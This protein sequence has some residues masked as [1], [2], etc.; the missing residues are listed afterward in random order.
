M[1]KQTRNIKRGVLLVL[2]IAT[3]V[4]VVVACKGG[5]DGTLRVGQKAIDFELRDL[6]GTMHRLSDYRGRR[7]HLHF[8]AD[9]CPLCH[10]EFEDMGNVYKELKKKYPDFEILGVNVDQPTVH[11]EEFIK[12]HQVEFPILLDVGS[13]VARAYGLKG[14]PCNFLVGRDGKIK[15]V[16]LGWVNEEYMKESLRKLE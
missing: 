4:F 15:D 11:V 13:K 6:D 3:A 1:M 8:W 5:G 9:W 7:I 14:I 2:L 12:K 16:L 10:K